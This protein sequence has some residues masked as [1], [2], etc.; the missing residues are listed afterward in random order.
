MLKWKVTLK[1]SFSSTALVTVLIFVS[2]QAVCKLSELDSSEKSKEYKDPTDAYVVG[3]AVRGNG[4]V[5]LL[6]FK[7]STR[8]FKYS[9]M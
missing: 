2:C 1:L 5:F 7:D 3:D 4:I 9:N 6:L 8:G